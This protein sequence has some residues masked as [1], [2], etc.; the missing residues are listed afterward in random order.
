MTRAHDR[1]E[2]I[3]TAPLHHDPPAFCCQDLLEIS[4]S[5]SSQHEVNERST[6]TKINTHSLF[7]KFHEAFRAP[8]SK[9]WQTLLKS[10]SSFQF[11]AYLL[12]FPTRNT[13]HKTAPGKLLQKKDLPPF[14][15]L[16]LLHNI[17]A[18]I[19][20]FSPDELGSSTNSKGI[21]GCHDIC[22]ADFGDFG[23][24]QNLYGMSLRKVLENVAKKA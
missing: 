23:L 22:L 24:Q 18:A 14:W 12:S 2:D 16:G 13:S 5:C 1:G 3:L 15:P 9:N 4:I 17:P 19:L 21:S 8:P 6:H 20:N 11:L 10:S 7:W